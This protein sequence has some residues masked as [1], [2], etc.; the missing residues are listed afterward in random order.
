MAALTQRERDIVAALVSGQTNAQ[1]AASL[2]I[3]D[4]TVRN[5]LTRIYGKLGVQSRT[6]AMALLRG[7]TP[8]G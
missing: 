7:S 6:Q 3:S 2:F 5:T 4:K 1:I 8:S